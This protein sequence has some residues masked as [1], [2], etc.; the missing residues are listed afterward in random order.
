MNGTL[1]SAQAQYQ[2]GCID[3]AMRLAEEAILEMEREDKG[4]SRSTYK[5][6]IEKIKSKQA[7]LALECDVRGVS[8]NQNSFIKPTTREGWTSAL[9]DF[10]R[11]H[12]TL[13]VAAEFLAFSLFIGALVAV[14]II[15][16]A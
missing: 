16:G 4:R 3:G 10:I 9:K 2:Q 14:L 12:G 5:K 11:E 13:T 6:A 1:Q 15:F 8:Y 7:T